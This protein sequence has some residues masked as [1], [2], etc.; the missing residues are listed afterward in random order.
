VNSV[1]ELAQGM[2]EYE[3]D[4][5]RLVSTRHVSISRVVLSQVEFGL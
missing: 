4:T 3:L 5:A 2:L 1:K